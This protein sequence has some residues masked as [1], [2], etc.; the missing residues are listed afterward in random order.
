LTLFYN[1]VYM[2]IRTKFFMTNQGT[3]LFEVDF[4]LYPDPNIPISIRELFDKNVDRKYWSVSQTGEIINIKFENIFKRN[5][6]INTEDP[7]T[8]VSLNLLPKFFSGKLSKEEKKNWRIEVYH[9]QYQETDWIIL[10]DDKIHLELFHKQW[11]NHLA[12]FKELIS[13]VE[14]IQELIK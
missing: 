10:V 4:Q 6:V 14:K 11:Q 1:G 13:E 9:S 2:D 5:M 8:I 7:L 12:T 3:F